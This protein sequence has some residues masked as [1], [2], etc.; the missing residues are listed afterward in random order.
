[1]TVSKCVLCGKESIVASTIKA[2]VSCLRNKPDDALVYALESHARSRKMF[3][4]PPYPPKSPGGLICRLCAAECSMGE[5]EK[6]FCGLRMNVGGR[7]ITK[8]SPQTGLLHY[9]FDP[10]VT[11]C[12]NAYFCPAGTGKGYPKYAYRP[13]PEVGYKNL[14]LFFYGCG[15]NCLFCQNWN[16]KIIS[17]SPIVS[18]QELADVTLANPSISCWC[19]FGGSPEPQLP[20]AVNAS[21]LIQECKPS[22]R[23]VRICYELNGDGNPVLVKRALETVV[24]SGGNV[25]FDLKA[26]DANIHRALTGLDNKAI[27]ENFEAVYRSFWERR[28]ELP[29]LAATTLL[30]PGYVDE[31]EVGKI[32]KFIASLSEEIPYSLLVFHPDFMMKDLPITPRTQVTACLKEA[33]KHLK[34]VN[35][36]NLHLLAF[37]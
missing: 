34:N 3:G 9:Y 33:K 21:K 24:K 16:H 30:V 26:F 31:V 4:L 23:I 29:V 27:L 19:W 12:C 18:A 20:F 35:V 5:G 22:N 2:C 15:L 17:Q 25:K 14:A 13:G 36:G 7:L 8:T 32:A 1:M 11:N 10:H 28:K 6:G 37:G